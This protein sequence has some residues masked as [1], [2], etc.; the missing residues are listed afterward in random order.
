MKIRTKLLLILLPLA[1]IPV[2]VAGYF[3]IVGLEN[4]NREAAIMLANALKL[5][6]ASREAAGKIEEAIAT[7]IN[8]DYNYIAGQFKEEIEYRY[9]DLVRL[10]ETTA[11]SSQVEAY[12]KDRPTDPETRDSRLRPFSKT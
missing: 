12:F 1:L 10:L 6:S 9:Q 5:E 11:A 8:N 7:Q 2:V 4:L 3:G